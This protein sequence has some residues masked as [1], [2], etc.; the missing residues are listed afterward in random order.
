MS[1]G[2]APV[3]EPPVYRGITVVAE[4]R[5]RSRVNPSSPPGGGAVRALYASYFHRDDRRPD[6]AAGPSGAGQRRRGVSVSRACAAPRSSRTRGCSARTRSPASAASRPR[7]WTWS[8]TPWCSLTSTRSWSRGRD[9]RVRQRTRLATSAGPKL[10]AIYEDDDFAQ[11]VLAALDDVMVPST[12]RSTTST[13]TSTRDRAGRL[14]RVAR[15]LGGHR[16]RRAAGTTPAGARSSRG[17]WA[18]PDAGTASRSP[19]QVGFQTGGDGR[20][21][22]ERGDS[23][24]VDPGGELRARRA[25]R[26][27]SGHRTRPKAIDANRLETRSCG[28]E[29]RPR[30]RPDRLAR[31]GAGEGIDWRRAVLVAGH[32]A[33]LSRLSS[34]RSTSD[35][36]SAAVIVW[37]ELRTPERGIGRVLRELRPVSGVG[38]Q[39]T[40]DRRPPRPG[41]AGPSDAAGA[42]S[43]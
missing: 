25:A 41:E 29:A 10:P 38:R 3:V 22:R 42:A 15:G 32:P 18:L 6:G 28:G 20:D 23:W 13:R 26:G 34:V 30:A 35:P 16:A 40:D 4:V 43:P 37:R 12:A 1:S 24:A 31:S 8:P 2:R 39:A 14:P 27:R 19:V 33:R 11:R 7:A 5:A 9:A 17:P 21:H 36:G